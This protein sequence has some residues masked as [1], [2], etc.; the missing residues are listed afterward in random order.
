[1]TAGGA[2]ANDMDRR[3]AKNWAL[4]IVLAG[5]ALLFYFVTMLRFGGQ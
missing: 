2:M 3:R 4:L 1:M 5:M